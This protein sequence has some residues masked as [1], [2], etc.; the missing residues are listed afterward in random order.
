MR[1]FY[2]AWKNEKKPIMTITQSFILRT[3]SGSSLNYISGS[4]SHNHYVRLFSS[5]KWTS[6]LHII[7]ELEFKVQ[8][9]HYKN[10]FDN[11]MGLLCS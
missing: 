9:G 2:K 7:S 4:F 1:L 5:A 8:D 11:Q 6:P 3:P 10:V